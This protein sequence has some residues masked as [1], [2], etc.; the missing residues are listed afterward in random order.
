MSKKKTNVN[1]STEIN[2][3]VVENQVETTETPVTEE[4]ENPVTENVGEAQPSET[5]S[6]NDASEVTENPVTENTTDEVVSN[7]EKVE[8]EIPPTVSEPTLSQETNN[9]PSVATTREVTGGDRY[10]TDLGDAG[11]GTTNPSDDDSSKDE[12]TTEDDTEIADKAVMTANLQKVYSVKYA[13]SEASKRFA[14]KRTMTLLSMYDTFVKN[15][16]IFIGLLSQ[17]DYLAIEK[18]MNEYVV[19]YKYKTV[20]KGA[21]EQFLRKLRNSTDYVVM[22]K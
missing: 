21:K 2:S 1:E 18:F 16:N 15:R 7:E 14:V 13:F 9:T 17:D 10:D 4:T 5:V 11:N 8:T 22:G 6:E 20:T 19:I 3:E 12:T